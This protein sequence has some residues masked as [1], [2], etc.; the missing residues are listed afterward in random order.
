MQRAISSTLNRPPPSTLASRLRRTATKTT[1]PYLAYGVSQSLFRTCGLQANYTIPESQRQGILTGQGPPKTTSGEDLG[2]PE[3]DS[4]WFQELGLQPTF[5]TWS[6]VTYLHMYMLVVRLRALEHRDSLAKYQHYLLD[7]FSH[8]AEERMILLHGMSA[9]GIRNRYLKDLFLQWRGLLTAYDEGLVKGDAVLA[10]AV[11]RNL[12]KGSE[13]VDWEKV[14]VVVGF[15]RRAVGLLGL[16]ADAEIQEAVVDGGVF[17][18]A[19][20]GLGNQVGR[21]SRGVKEVPNEE[22]VRPSLP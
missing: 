18:R 7:H 22:E 21:E 4:W 17:E 1:D 11:W 20:E 12:W 8:A 19:R 5:S 2:M 13:E 15:V 16:V 14:A 3:S 9:R 10:G 6:Q